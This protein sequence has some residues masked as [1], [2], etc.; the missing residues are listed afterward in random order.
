MTYPQIL[1]ACVAVVA[2]T[3]AAFTGAACSTP[4]ANGP[5]QV[6]DL[7]ERYPISVQPR[8]MTL[9]LLYN[10]QAALDENAT[11][12]IARF[13]Q[14]Y[15]S[16]G[17]GSIAVAPPS[18]NA[19]VADLVIAELLERGVSRNQIMVGGANAPG[20]ADDIRLTYIRYVAEAPPCGDWSGNRAYTANNLPP[21]N[22]GCAMQHNLAAMVADPRDLVTP[23]TSGQPDAQ[24]RLTVLDQYRK[25]EPTPA[26]K[27]NEQSA[28][29][30]AVGM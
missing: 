5:D 26:Q 23:D 29:I 28:V 1:R 4:V 14:D 2:V 13:A 30:T 3:A 7:N 22:F 15:L 8:M 17:S 6:F 16:H 25:G 18:G 11:G 19:G 9:R 12:Q 21:S 20:P 27:T 24:R 10:G